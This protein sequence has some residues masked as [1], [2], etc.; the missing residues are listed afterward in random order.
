[1]DINGLTQG[2]LAFANSPQGLA[3]IVGA[4]LVIAIKVVQMTKIKKDDEFLA[5]WGR[6]LFTAADLIEKNI[7]DGTQIPILQ[8]IDRV[9]KEIA[10]A[11]QVDVS[12]EK[13]MTTIK[14]QLLKVAKESTK[15]DTS[16]SAMEQLKN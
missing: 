6:P 8:Y 3:I 15:V 12:N 9:C 2:I 1:M 10:K 13:L 14:K 7:K 16:P 5:R 4:V 11:G